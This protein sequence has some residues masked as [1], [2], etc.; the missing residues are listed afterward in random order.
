MTQGWISSLNHLI[1]IVIII[2]LW[3]SN[4]KYKIQIASGLIILGCFFG[5]HWIYISLH[6]FGGL[7]SFLAIFATGILSLYVASY[8]LISGVLIRKFNMG[9]IC[10]ASVICIAEWTK[11]NFLTGFPWLNIGVNQVDSIFSFYAP[12][13]G[14]FGVGFIA[15]YFA[16]LVCYSKKWCLIF[17]IFISLFA[18]I[19]N[20][21]S[22]SIKAN[23]NVLNV[24]LVQ[25]LIPQDL[26]FLP[27]EEQKAVS[28]HLGLAQ[29]ALEKYPETD[30]IVLPETAFTKPWNK[31][32]LKTHE[33]IKNLLIKN[34]STL[35]AG[36]PVTEGSEWK[37]SLVAVKVDG[38]SEL[39]II[40]VYNKHH[41]VP[42]GEFIPLGFKW[43]IEMMNIPLGNF[44]RGVIPQNPIKIKDQ[45]LGVNICFEDL[46]GN[47]IAYIFSQKNSFNHPNI[48][49]NVS[50]LAWFGN[51]NA[52]D[53]HLKASR[54]RSLETGR[55]MIRATNT[56]VTA[57]VDHTGKILSSLPKTERGFLFTKIQGTEGNT[58]Y[59]LAGDYIILIFSVLVLFVN[60]VNRKKIDFKKISKKVG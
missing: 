27:Y 3:K 33:K 25:G 19:L 14:S 54:M 6:K 55:P 35:M 52:L 11:S 12:F 42:F 50:N 23:G 17:A 10:I 51:S 24:V 45:F 32:D 49:L 4:S 18:G 20:F 40:G 47:E 30:L 46:F 41:L 15:T 31:L 26:K 60:F 53:Y 9:P 43:F 28:T 57:S 37:N 39:K 5:L 36:V 58:L 56:G 16:A 8:Y 22:S 34:D 48:L 21:L 2:F 59:N 38:F 13:L 1:F 7:N 44:S 29:S